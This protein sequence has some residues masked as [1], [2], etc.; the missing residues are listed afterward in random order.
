MK[1]ETVTAIL[2]FI[3]VSS[4]AV[5]NYHQHE[6]M[7]IQREQMNIQREKITS[8]ES[9]MTEMRKLLSPSEEQDQRRLNE[10]SPFT[11][12]GSWCT[13]DSNKHFHFPKGVLI[14]TKNDSCSYGSSMLSVDHLGSNCP[15]SPGT[16][17]FGFNNA[18]SG[19]RSMV[20]GGYDNV[21]SGP[22]SF[23]IGARDS[24]ASGT[25]R[26][27]VIGGW[28][29]KASGGAGNMVIGGQS[30]EASG[31]QDALV[32]NSVQAF[33]T[34]QNAIV[35]GS[36]RSKARA[37]YST[38]VGGILNEIHPIDTSSFSTIVGGYMNEIRESRYGSVFGG[39]KN[40]VYGQYATVTGGYNN[41]STGDY[42]SVSGGSKNKAIGDYSSV[43]GG[44]QNKARGDYSSILG[45]KN[46]K[47][48]K[49]NGIF[50]KNKK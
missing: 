11:C 15:S 19:S 7:N 2:T 45:A 21:A 37:V 50:P 42:S 31:S 22:D 33:A 39:Y 36:W 6:Q 35:F 20:L 30:S 34:A 29:N 3:A 10:E 12:D 28:M 47:V 43:S 9:E 23:I 38:I 44:T 14:G 13:A 18:A 49:K 8:M 26:S 27:S 32:I 24:E 48:L 25:S 41:T 5:V 1:G 16:V 46:K 40:G 17:T 4:L